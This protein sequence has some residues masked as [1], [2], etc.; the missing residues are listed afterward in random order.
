[1]Y[2]D[3]GSTENPT[4]LIWMSR[5]LNWT[6]SFV[7]GLKCKD[8]SNSFKLYR[9]EA[10]RGLDLYCDN[11]DIIEEILFKL[12]RANRD[13]RIREV[14]FAFKSRMFGETKRNLVVFIATY[15]ITMVKLRLSIYSA[16]LRKLLPRRYRGAAMR[17]MPAK[18]PGAAAA[19]PENKG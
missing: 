16:F 10:L 17:Q 7:L 18:D 15:I 13:L 1:R 3:G 4:S 6:Y 5:I 14:P 8:V 2:V 11:F 19:L 9:G 12:S